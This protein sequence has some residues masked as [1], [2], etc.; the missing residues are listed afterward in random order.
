MRWIVWILMLLSA[1]VGLALLMR[2]NHGNVAVL[3]PP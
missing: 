1:A 3:W 2:V